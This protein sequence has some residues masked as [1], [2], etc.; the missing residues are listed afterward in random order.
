MSQRTPAKTTRQ[1]VR[2]L[3]SGSPATTDGSPAPRSNST[4]SVA[5]NSA[6]WTWLFIRGVNGG[7]GLCLLCEELAQTANPQE[8]EKIM[9]HATIGSCSAT[10]NKSH[11]LRRHGL[12]QDC[13]KVQAKIE[14]VEA[15]ARASAGG[16]TVCEAFSTP[17]SEARFYDY[18][19]YFAR[20][21]YECEDPRFRES[22]PHA[23]ASAKTLREKLIAHSAMR[24]SQ[25]LAHS[26]NTTGHSR[27]TAARFGPSTSVWLCCPADR[28]L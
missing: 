26:R 18:M 16:N 5:N 20:P 4:A 23:P 19:L 6:S 1:P 8:K 25:A 15:K 10:N 3:S 17:A 13:P 11:L 21:L 2:S 7:G 14:E 12:T 24:V 9:R 22:H 28:C 27:S